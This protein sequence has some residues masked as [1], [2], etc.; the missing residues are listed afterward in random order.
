[1]QVNRVM[2]EYKKVEQA[3][4]RYLQAEASYERAR[5]RFSELAG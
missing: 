2:R 3:R 4:R 5:Q 1:M